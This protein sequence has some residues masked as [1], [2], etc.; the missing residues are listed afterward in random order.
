MPQVRG[1]TM[2]L[3]LVY[4]LDVAKQTLISC[5]FCSKAVDYSASCSREKV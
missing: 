4:G 2:L 1:T 5:I 3:P